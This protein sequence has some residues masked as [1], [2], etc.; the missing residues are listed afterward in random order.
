MTRAYVHAPASVIAPFDYTALIYASVIGIL[1]FGDRLDVEVLIGGA[2]VVGAGLF[3]FYRERYLGLP[4][5]RARARAVGP[6][7]PPTG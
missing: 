6:P 2:L 7:G 1:V 4:R 5:G 3:I